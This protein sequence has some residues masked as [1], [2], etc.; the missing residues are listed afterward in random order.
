MAFSPADLL[1][2]AL[3]RH[4]V[5]TG[6]FVASA[7][8]PGTFARSLGP[9]SVGD[10]AFVTGVVTALTYATTVAT[11][12]ALSALAGAAPRDRPPR[13]REDVRRRQLA[14]ELVAVPFGLAV[15]RALPVRDDERLI[16]SA[17]RQ[18][19]WRAGLTGLGS[20]LLT[21]TD[22]AVARLDR[23]L[24]AGGRISGLPVAVPAGLLVAGCVEWVRRRNLP[25][26][27]QPDRTPREL[28]TALT[29][30][31]AV[32]TGLTVLAV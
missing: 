22:A 24:G 32:T 10:Q 27:D 8:A 15:G 3:N 12:D 25:D 11:Q 9:R 28:A 21:G 5:Q 4:G 2:R 29:A 31:L 19:A 30:G 26:D 16:R 17:A 14:V 1:G 7:I 20:L 13:S 6:L 23:R 18:V